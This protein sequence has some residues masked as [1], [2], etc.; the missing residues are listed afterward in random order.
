M[1]VL[2]KRKAGKGNRRVLVGEDEM[3]CNFIK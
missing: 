2:E 1:H 3:G